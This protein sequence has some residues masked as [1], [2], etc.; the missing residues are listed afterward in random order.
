MKNAREKLNNFE[1]RHAAALA[2]LD[3]D[4]CFQLRALRMSRG[5]TQEE[6]AER[7]GMK[8]SS[9]A[10]LESRDVFPARRTIEKLAKAF[11]IAYVFQFV[12]FDAFVEHTRNLNFEKLQV[13][14]YQVIDAEE[15]GDDDL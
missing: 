15:E 13:P 12:S 7:A 3:I 14:P 6:L 10:R 11:D 5:W 4:F 1:Y 8:Q 9:V 2:Q